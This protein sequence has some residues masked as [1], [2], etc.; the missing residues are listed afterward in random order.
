MTPIRRTGRS[1]AA[2]LLA[3]TCALALAT[4]ALAQDADLARRVS[5]AV[6][7]TPLDRAHWGIVIQDAASGEVLYERNA[8]RLFIPASNL[9]LVVATTAASLLPSDFRLRTSLYGTGPVRDG[10]LEGDLVLYGR[11]DPGIS[12]RYH[13]DRMLA[14]WEALA[15]SLA[16]RGVRQVRGGLVADES[17]FDSTHVHGDWES[18]DLLWWYAAPV[19]ALGFNDNSIDFRIMPGAVG[20][21]ARID[22]QPAT[23]FFTLA[24]RTRTVRAD[25]AQTLD[26]MRGAGDTIIAYGTLPADARAWTEYFAVEDPARYAGTVFR[27]VLEA[28]GIRFGAPGVA[29]Q[30]A[31]DRSVARANPVEL[32]GYDSA[33][34]SELIFP[35]LNASQNWFAEQLLKTL[36][37]NLGSDASWEAGIEVEERFLT[38]RVGLD[39]SE[40]RLRDASGLSAGN[41]ITP[42]ALARLLLYA[43]P[44]EPVQE[45][46]PVAAA[47]RG[48]LRTRF[49]DLPGRVR[50]K[51]GGIR[52]VD[53]L[54][55]YVTTDTGRELVF[56]VIA[57]GSAFPGSVVRAAIDDV[58]RAAAQTD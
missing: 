27:E 14:V 49:A 41:L 51:T 26:F 29:V 34:L 5:A 40:F 23:S 6:D 12:G 35:I 56:V 33:P 43:R 18:Y 39:E 50:A 7:R 15:D 53:A 37:R 55:G 47:A 32:A 57:N 36:G 52:N 8:D 2:A 11:G 44:L 24:N 46:L 22:W 28:R 30:R 3:L 20:E 54:S 13:D 16:A 42:R 45:A 4:P 1:R 38:E 25:G 9:K 17:W 21:P 58:V 19:G 10:V 31:P 48:S